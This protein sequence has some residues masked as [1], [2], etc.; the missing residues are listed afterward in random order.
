MHRPCGRRGPS[1]SERGRRGPSKNERRVSVLDLPPGVGLLGTPLA[2]FHAPK[3]A[4]R[5]AWGGTIVVAVLLVVTWYFVS[6]HGWRRGTSTM[7]ILPVALLLFTGLAVAVRTA[8]VAI[9]RDGIR[10]GWT[11]L[12]F[13]QSASRIVMAHIYTDGIAFQ[14]TRGSK[15]F[16]A[17][18]DWERFDVLV[19]QVRRA[20]LPTTDHD[21]KAP[22]RQRL[23]SYGRVLD[24]LVVFS[25]IAAVAVVSWAA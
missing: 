8:R 23:Q 14:A 18:R 20:E 12:S 24:S 13:T 9:T 10:W 21:G 25:V 1:E 5:L 3:R 17:A 22:F 6:Q 4:K 19:R 15:W 2:T 16:L 7:V 11:A